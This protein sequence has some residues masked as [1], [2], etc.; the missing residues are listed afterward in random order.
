MKY[1]LHQPTLD[2]HKGEN[3]RLLVIGGSTLFHASIF[4]SAD[5]ASR[6]VDLVHFSSPAN[7]NNNLVRRKLKTGFWN[8]IVVDFGKIAEYLVEDDCILIGPGMPRNEGLFEGEIPTRQ[9]VSSLLMKYSQKKWVIDGGA[10]Q[11]LD[12]SLLNEN[13]IITPHHKEWEGLLQRDIGITQ[14]PEITSLLKFNKNEEVD[15]SNLSRLPNEKMARVVQV[16]SKRH[17]NVTV[18]LKG[19]VDIVS[20][21]DVVELVSGGNP[22][23]TKGGTGDVL[24]GLTAALY[25]KN[26]PFTSAIIASQVLKR[27]G[28]NLAKQVGN[29]FNASDLVAQVPRTLAQMMR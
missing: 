6:V 23:M 15:W 29:Y 20:Q 8:G 5:V 24:A 19:Q 17:N 27:A 26:N 13:M 14:L 2:S 3:G 4:W 18:L 28:E 11:D 21:G 10:L 7:E 16:F 1:K 12:V 9:L 22:G 25:C